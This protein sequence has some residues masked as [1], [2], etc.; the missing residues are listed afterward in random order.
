MYHI[1]IERM[2]LDK[3]I[4]IKGNK[5]YSPD[6]CLIVPQSINEIF[7]SS[8]RKT[9]DIDLPYT[10]LR[11][12]KGKYSVSFRSK[13]LGVYDTVDKALDAYLK[14]KKDYIRQKVEEMENELPI[15][16]RDAL[17]AW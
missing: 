5:V 8:G 12:S 3:D 1:G 7:H 16:V 11:T 4:L 14:V 10:I 9:K 2:H 6:T 17:L 15:K 13:S